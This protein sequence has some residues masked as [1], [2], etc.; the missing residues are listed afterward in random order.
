M[1]SIKRSLELCK[2]YQ[3]EISID[4]EDTADL[5][6]LA[7]EGL[8]KF[9]LDTVHVCQTAKTTSRGLRLVR[10]YLN[11]KDTVT[12]ILLSVLPAAVGLGIDDGRGFIIGISVGIGLTLLYLRIKTGVFW[13]HL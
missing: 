5:K 3:E 9:G 8:I 11:T 12:M 10:R 6:C 7:C 2:K 13:P 1:I 4:N